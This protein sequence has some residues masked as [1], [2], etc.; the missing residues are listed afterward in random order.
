MFGLIFL[1]LMVIL[2]STIIGIFMAVLGNVFVAGSKYVAGLWMTEFSYFDFS[3]FGVSVPFSVVGLALAAIIIYLLRRLFFLDRFY[4]PADS[5]YAAHLAKSNID[6]GKGLQS[7][8]IAFVS[9]AGGAPVGQ[10]GPLVHLGALV[11]SSFHKFLTVTKTSSD[12]WIGC[13]VAAAIAAGFQAP[14]AGVVF[15]HEAVLRH[16]S[17]RAITPILVASITSYALTKNWFNLEPLFYIQFPSV[18]LLWSIPSLLIGGFA[19]G[20]VAVLFMRSLLFFATMGKKFEHH[21]FA[22]LFIAFLTCAA[23]GTVFPAVLG[24]GSATITSIF[25]GGLTLG[26]LFA[27]LICKLLASS[28]AIGFGMYGGVFAPALFLGATAG[29]FLTKLF[30]VFG[31][32]LPAHLLPIAG[33]ASVTA[34]VIGAPL[35]MVIIILELTLSYELAVIAMVSTAVSIQVASLWFNHSFF[36]EQLSR[37]GIN[38]LKGRTDLQLGQMKVTSILTQEY[39]FLPPGALIKDGINDLK[40]NEKSEGY[41]VDSQNKFIGKFLLVELLGADENLALVDFCLSAPIVLSE[42]NSVLDAVKIATDFVGESMPVL[43]SDTGQVLG[44]I[45]EAD[46]FKVYINVQKKASKTEHV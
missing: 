43:S 29:G 23:I 20:I 36:D 21:I 15:A 44:V 8:L 16:L 28:V 33:M 42:S 24:F 17:F 19:F 26:T 11:G 31:A 40:K 39:V 6:T 27:L 13:G 14:I 46:I 1:S 35:S 25:V 34:C 12:L 32:A 5:I 9:I 45:S 3:V 30:S 22:G 37:R 7:T 2:F 18:E 38:L 41:C 10:Y 4:G